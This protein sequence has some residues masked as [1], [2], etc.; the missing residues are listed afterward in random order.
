MRTIAEIK[1]DMA[2][3]ESEWA[4][5]L[6]RHDSAACDECDRR[7]TILVEELWAAGGGEE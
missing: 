1:A 5:A 4:A 6:A 2:S 7:Y 3:V